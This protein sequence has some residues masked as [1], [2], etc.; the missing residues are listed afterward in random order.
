MKREIKMTADGS[1]TLYV[2]EIDEHYHSIHGAVQESDHVFIDKGIDALFLKEVKVLE[3]GFG[4]G[5]NCLLTALWSDK[6]QLKVHYTGIDPF[7]IDE[8]LNMSL[9]YPSQI[10]LPKAQE[11]FDKII[12]SEW[13]VP[14]SVHDQFVL[15]K[16]E[17][18]IEDFESG[19]LYDIIYF[20]AFGPNAQKELWE[21][22]IL[23]SVYTLMDERSIFVTYCAKGQLKRDLSSIGFTVETLKGPPGKREMTRA[24]KN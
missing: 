23:E 13:E 8:K 12:G 10:Q 11:Y 6:H 19:E 22:H 18:R 2:P 7:P 1:Q 24:R 20:D 21:Y 14:L 3:V 5:L 4:T 9:N 17:R 16:N 15:T